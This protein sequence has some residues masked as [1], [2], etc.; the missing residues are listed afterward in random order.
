MLSV[1][2][3]LHGGTH[4]RFERPDRFGDGVLWADTRSICDPAVAHDWRA[5][6]S[7]GTLAITAVPE[8]G[9]AAL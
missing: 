6:S 8:A 4:W 5:V 1:S 2:G 3:A 7:N 9:P